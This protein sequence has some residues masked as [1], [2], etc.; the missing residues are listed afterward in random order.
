MKVVI[1]HSGNKT[2]SW[3]D[4]T[5]VDVVYK[6]AHQVSR[7]AIHYDDKTHMVLTPGTKI[8]IDG[9]WSL[10]YVGDE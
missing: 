1:E 4:A 9:V 2:K 10:D 7:C 5:S 3:I 8:T 6:G